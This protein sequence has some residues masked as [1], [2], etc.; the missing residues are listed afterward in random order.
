MPRL[1]TVFFLLTT[2]AAWCGAAPSAVYPVPQRMETAAPSVAVTRCDIDLASADNMPDWAAAMPPREGAYAFRVGTDGTLVLRAHDAAGLFYAKQSLCQLLQGVEGALT[3]HA[4]PFPADEV[5]ALVQRGRLPV[6]TVVDWPDIPRRGVVEGYYGIPWSTEQRRSMFRFFGRNKM[7]FYLYAPKDDPY[8]HGAGCY[9]LYPPDKARELA[10]LVQCARENHVRFAWAIHPS[11]TVRWAEQGGE[12]QL[13]GLCAKMQAMYELGIRDFAVLV[14]DTT[15]EIGTAER[16]IQLCNYLTEHFIKTH[17]DVTQELIMCPTGY[18]RAWTPASFLQKLGAGLRPEIRVMWTGDRVVSDITRSGQEW[19][20]TALGRPTFIWWNRPCND[21]KANRLQMGRI[22]GLEQGDAMKNLFSGFVANPME[23]AEASKIGLAGVADY[24]W[25][26]NGYVSQTSWRTALRRLYP[27]TAGAFTCFCEHNSRLM[28]WDDG[29]TREESVNLTAAAPAFEASLAAAA[30]DAAAVVHLFR[31]YFRVQESA[32]A[33]RRASTPENA[34]LRAEIDPWLQ[35]FERTGHAGRLL[36]EAVSGKRPALETLL[37]AAADK[38]AMQT[39]E[40]RVWRDG[41]VDTMRDVQVGTAALTPALETAFRYVN[42]L[43]LHE[44]TGQG[45]RAH[46][47]AFSDKHG[48]NWAASAALGNG[49]EETCYHA[50]EAQQV[51]DTFTL[52]F[53]ELTPISSVELQM[54]CIHDRQG[55]A[56]AGIMEISQDGQT[57]QPLGGETNQS[58][59]M[60]DFSAAPRM[61]RLL[62]YRITRCGGTPLTIRNFCINR[63]VP[64][65]MQTDIPGLT[66]LSAFENERAIGMERLYETVTVPPAAYLQM[67][68]G[69]PVKAKGFRL[70][71]E[72]ADAE[73]WVQIEL[74]LADGTVCRPAFRVVRPG[75][76]LVEGDNMPAEPVRSVRITNIGNAP[77]PLLFY[78][79]MLLLP[80]AEP[81]AD[82][83]YLTDGDLSTGCA[84]DNISRTL[85]LENPDRARCLHLIGTAAAE[86]TPA[87]VKVE[88]VSPAHTIY[89][90]PEKTESIDITLPAQ[91]GKRVEELILTPHP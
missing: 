23:H 82:T 69:R 72:D 15:G 68:P 37:T 78:T 76:L 53:G 38:R 16:Q 56:E 71:I 18:C 8:H 10:E 47:P 86:T 46:L 91:N 14:D 20:N 25:N 12:V 36:C 67:T 49:S 70:A 48:V 61:A 26:I 79:F 55:T 74:T 13:Q 75:C 24:T 17:P 89:H 44:I 62:R 31:E 5:P 60:H 80:P 45:G 58:C 9:E 27:E 41:R 28:A 88:N 3:P 33:L 65:L 90:L 43:A 30:P 1:L 66:A 87:A 39:A 21:M 54:G 29:P 4:D 85:R 57:W 19:A 6:C 81:G 77:R 40:R 11:D 42:A 83:H 35:N 59:L 32:A 51:G 64:A 63:T 7:N 52:D 34:A 2:L 50:P 84:T 22:Y 73:N